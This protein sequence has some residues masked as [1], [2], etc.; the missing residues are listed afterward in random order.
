MNKMAM[1]L[2]ASADTI[3]NLTTFYK[4]TLANMS[5]D[6]AGLSGT[7]PDTTFSGDYAKTS[8]NAYEQTIASFATTV[9]KTTP[10]NMVQNNK[11]FVASFDF[12]RK[13]LFRLTELSAK[14]SEY[15]MAEGIVGNWNTPIG[16][17]VLKEINANLPEGN[18]TDIRQMTPQ[19]IARLEGQKA[20][21]RDISAKF[22]DRLQS[23]AFL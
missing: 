22:T 17:R 23:P 14:H 10:K 7:R 13:Q 20:A 12:M 4:A 8:A 11:D 2:H 21:L 15:R 3:A 16:R 18:I 19:T 9:G 6:I 5:G 1:L